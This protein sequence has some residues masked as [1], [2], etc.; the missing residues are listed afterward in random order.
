M[1]ICFAPEGGPV[2]FP[3]RGIIA[4]AIA[5]GSAGIVLAQLPERRSRSLFWGADREGRASTSSA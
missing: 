3:L 1:R 2:D 5:L 4:D